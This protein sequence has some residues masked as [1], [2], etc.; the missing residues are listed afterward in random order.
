NSIATSA[1]SVAAPPSPRARE[2]RRDR[3][4]KAPPAPTRLRARARRATAAYSPA[5]HPIRARRGEAPRARGL[6][7]RPPG[8]SAER[9]RHAVDVVGRMHLG[10]ADQKRILERR[11]PLTE[12]HAGEHTALDRA[13]VPNAGV[14]QADHELVEKRRGERELR[15]GLL[16]EAAR[17]VVSLPC[18][19]LREVAQAA[20]AG[21]RQEHGRRQR[22]QSLVRAD[23]RRRPLAPD[24][25]LTGGEREHVAAATLLVHGLSDEPPGH[26][27]HEALATGKE[28]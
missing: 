2:S 18:I 14:R 17:R 6:G 22:A 24:V 25:L 4:G 1:G 8:S 7:I 9:F 15:S 21:E 27:A 19:A 5:G 23:V 12:R 13:F 26:A 3:P 16:A 20:A 28:A 10:R 11:E